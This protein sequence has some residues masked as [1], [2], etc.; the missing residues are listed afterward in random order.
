[1][2]RQLAQEQKKEMCQWQLG[3]CVLS[4]SCH[5]QVCVLLYITLFYKHTYI[6]ILC[7]FAL[8]LSHTHRGV[9][10]GSPSSSG[11]HYR[12][13]SKTDNVWVE[14]REPSG[15]RLWDR[16]SHISGRRHLSDS[17]QEYGELPDSCSSLN[18]HRMHFLCELSALST[19][20]SFRKKGNWLELFQ[21]GSWST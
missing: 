13:V 3:S 21:A 11:G 19:H 7:G 20:R 10:A 12:D 6:Q 16:R 8:S 17:S 9:W 18:Q 5:S 4:V 14:S 2:S 1:M 15:P